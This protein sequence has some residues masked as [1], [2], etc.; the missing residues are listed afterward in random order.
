MIGYIK[1]AMKLNEAGVKSPTRS[2]KKVKAEL[3]VPA[4]LIAALKKSSKARTTFE[5]LSASHRREYIEWI[6]E[7]K[8]E[9]TRQRRVNTAVEWMEQGKPRN[10]KYM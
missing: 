5:G 2:V 9:E 1:Q 4:E 6:V 7:A 10:W 8:R 3:P